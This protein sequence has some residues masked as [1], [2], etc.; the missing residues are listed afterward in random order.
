M[1]AALVGRGIDG[2][3]IVR[4]DGNIGK[5]GVLADIQ[6]LLPALTS[7]GGFVEPAVATWGP[8]RTF[9]GNE[10][11]VAVLRTNRDAANML[12]MLQ[13]NIGPTLAAVFGFVYSIA[14]IDTA[15]RVVLARADPH[16]RGISRIK[17]HVT[18]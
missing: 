4:I 7:I 16:D 13:A 10:N 5:A 14:V 1:A 9:G 8:Q 18:D 15:L 3:R 2:V 6:D 11:R 12:R 17:L